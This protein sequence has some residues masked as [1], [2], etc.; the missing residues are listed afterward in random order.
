M[1]F[2]F[3]IDGRQVTLDTL[4]QQDL[5]PSQVRLL[6]RLANRV[7]DVVHQTFCAQHK[8]EIAVAV[9][10]SSTHGI[11]TR[12]N[13]CCYS[14]IHRTQAQLRHVLDET[15][16]VQRSPHLQLV[17]TI[18]GTETRLVFDVN[19]AEELSIGRCDSVSGERPDIDLTPFQAHEKGVSRRHA[20]L[21]WLRQQL[22][23]MDCESPNG[24]FLNEVRLSPHEPNTIRYKDV[25][26]L[27]R[28]SLAISVEHGAITG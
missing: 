21:L 3:E 14:I 17:L 16:Q 19:R 6:Y 26:C 4:E 28:L 20:K 1:V 24:T 8:T 18:Q 5:P 13:G 15:L 7:E 10:V 9:V 23:I 27:G 25:I 11:G 2:A 22:Y 12:V